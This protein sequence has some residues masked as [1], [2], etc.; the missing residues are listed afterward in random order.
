[1]RASTELTINLNHLAYNFDLLKKKCPTNSPIFMVKANA[2][3]H[4]LLEVVDYAFNELGVKDFGCASLGEALEI[5]KKLPKL[6]CRIFVF[7]DT[8]IINEDYNQAYVDYNILPVITTLSDLDYVLNHKPF[9]YLPLVIHFD[10]GMNRLGISYKDMDQ[11]ISLLNKKGIKTLTHVMT[12]FSQSY[13]PN[14]PGGKTE[15]QLERYKEILDRFDSEGIKYL[16]TSCANSGAIEQKTGLQFTHIRPG[17][18]LYGPP[19]TGK[20]DLWPSKNLSVFKT[21]ILRVFPIKKGTPVG[22]GG[23]VC[24][25]DGFVAYIPVGYGDGF[26]T[27]FSGASINV[28]GSTAKILGR[29]NMDLTALFFETLPHGVKENSE[30]TLWGT[31]E[32][33]I[34][35]LAAQLKTI[36]YQI[37]TSI[38]DR[39][40]RRYIN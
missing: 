16:E 23:H 12:H 7:S 22:Y 21:K 26:L 40:S 39:V 11:L 8:E 33:D 19:G 34:S 20:R 27:Y 38:T 6:T 31:E 29:V 32:E 25:K 5:R 28:A 37:F 24:G 18:M 15:K 35:E 14:K 2:Y 4:G 10:T 3:G 1:M 36:P 17:L 9:K 13:L 30:M